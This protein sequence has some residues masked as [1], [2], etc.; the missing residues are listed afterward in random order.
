MFHNGWQ[1]TKSFQPPS[2][3]SVSLFWNAFSEDKLNNETGTQQQWRYCDHC[4]PIATQEVVVGDTTRTLL[5]VLMVNCM[6]PVPWRHWT[7]GLFQVSPQWM[8]SRNTIHESAVEMWV[9]FFW[10]TTSDHHFP[11]LKVS[12][13]HLEPHKLWLVDLGCFFVDPQLPYT[14]GTWGHLSYP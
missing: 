10:S 12:P 5:S 8:P 1:S 7:N 3:S 14:W 11:K 6:V 13:Y 2:H 4:L 9:C